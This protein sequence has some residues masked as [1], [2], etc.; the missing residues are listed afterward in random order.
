MRLLRKDEVT[1]SLEIEEEPS[2]VRGNFMATED[3]EQDKRD[4]DEIIARLRRGD[5]WAWC[6]VKVTATWG[7]FSDY[8]YLGGCSYADEK[9]FK[10]D[11]YYDGMCDEAFDALNVKLQKLAQKLEP[12]K[13]PERWPNPWAREVVYVPIEELAACVDGLGQHCVNAKGERFV[14]TV[15]TTLAHWRQK[16]PGERLDAYILPQADGYHPI[17]IRYGAEPSEYL[18]PFG[19][20]AKVAALL[21]KYS[22][23][24]K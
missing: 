24:A 4:E 7:D 10:R 21:A 11:G 14:M 3:L 6:T 18:S 20:R 19:E 2:P 23:K 5:D 8:A 16:G 9:D 13:D 17:G 1:F 12:L 15:E 22:P